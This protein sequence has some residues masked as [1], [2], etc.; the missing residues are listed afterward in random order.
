MFAIERKALELI[1]KSLDVEFCFSPSSLLG[2][3]LTIFMMEWLLFLLSVVRCIQHRSRMTYLISI[4]AKPM[5]N[6][7][8]LELYISLHY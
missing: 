7:I 8:L 4:S 2:I 3:Y 5:F 6:Q 1:D